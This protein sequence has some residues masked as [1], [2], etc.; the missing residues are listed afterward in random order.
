MGIELTNDDGSPMDPRVKAAL[1]Q[2]KGSAVGDQYGGQAP[3]DDHETEAR[4]GRLR[5][6]I[7]SAYRSL[8]RSI[9]AYGSTFRGDAFK[10][11][12]PLIEPA[13]AL[14]PVLRKHIVVD[15]EDQW[16]AGG[17]VAW[18]AQLPN[19]PDVWCLVIHNV[20]AR[21]LFKDRRLSGRIGGGTDEEKFEK[22]L[23]SL[24]RI[25][26]DINNAAAEGRRGDG[27]RY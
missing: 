1:F 8:C 10:A 9:D 13:A 3:S 25:A 6:A 14:E 27:Y 21:Y 23:A 11:L 24:K 15:S 2:A 7:H 22:T 20:P 17:P 26:N 5:I 18:V 12:E 4:R 16:Q 19:R